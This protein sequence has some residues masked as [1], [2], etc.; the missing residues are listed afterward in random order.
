MT[1]QHLISTKNFIKLL[2]HQN[3]RI[4]QERIELCGTKKQPILQQTTHR[5]VCLYSISK[6]HQEECIY[7]LLLFR[8]KQI[9][10]THT[11]A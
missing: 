5:L 10:H 1:M 9:K 2:K 4:E 6:S 7:T 3:S 11:H 8:T